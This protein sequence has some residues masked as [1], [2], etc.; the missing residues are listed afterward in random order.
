MPRRLAR[1]L[2]QAHLPLP[3][4]APCCR[5]AAGL[6][7]C[8]RRCNMYP[9][10]RNGR[11]PPWPLVEEVAWVRGWLVPTVAP[12]PPPP[13]GP[14]VLGIV[15]RWRGLRL[16]KS[17]RRRLHA[18]Q[19]ISGRAV[20]MQAAEAGRLNPRLSESA[21]PQPRTAPP[22]LSVVSCASLLSTLVPLQCSRK[23]YSSGSPSGLGLAFCTAEVVDRAAAPCRRRRKGGWASG[24]LKVG[25]TPRSDTAAPAFPALPLY[26]Q[27]T[28]ELPGGSL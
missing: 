13:A 17:A 23:M 3:A 10:G 6:M 9:G 28:S 27:A 15:A 14:G 25:T 22:H 19:T 7:G 4:G 21:A 26:L 8:C 18:R 16:P 20:A 12:L 11:P 2:P 1:R 5:P 24:K